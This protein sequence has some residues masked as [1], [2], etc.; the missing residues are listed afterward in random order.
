MAE[1]PP[2]ELLEQKI[3]AL[4]REI[5]CRKQNEQERENKLKHSSSTKE[6]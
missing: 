3:R 1:K 6:M 2:Y 4:E 5:A